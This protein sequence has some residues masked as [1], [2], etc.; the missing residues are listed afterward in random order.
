MKEG[1]LHFLKRIEIEKWKE[2]NS[3]NLIVVPEL[4]TKWSCVMFFF[5]N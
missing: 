4:E 3:S 1:K 2:N 5:F